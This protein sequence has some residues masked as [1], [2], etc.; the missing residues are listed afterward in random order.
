MVHSILH[1]YLSGLTLFFHNPYPGFLWYLPVGLTVPPLHNPCTFHP[2][3]L[4][5][6]SY[7]RLMAFFPG[8]PG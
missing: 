1:V 4:T 6:T 7:I 8:Q 2:V 5:T 3:I